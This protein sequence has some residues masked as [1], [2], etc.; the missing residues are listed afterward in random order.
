M[1]ARE[2]VTLSRAEYDA[3]IERTADLEDRLAATEAAGDARV[4]H[5]VAL[6]VIEGE[7]PV[8][9]FRDHRGLTLRELS[10]R[11]GVS[12]GYLSEIERG[13]KPGS[14]RRHDADRRGPRRHH[15][16]PRDQ[17]V[18]EPDEPARPCALQGD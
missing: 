14:V 12:L 11:S 18:A 1:S 16:Q 17:R 3:L 2:T 7:S 9:A 6:A 8:R 10:R 13:R 5:E 15:R 4:P